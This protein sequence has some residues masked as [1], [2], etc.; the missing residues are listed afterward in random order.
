[1]FALFEGRVPHKILE[2]WIISPT[3]GLPSFGLYLTINQPYLGSLSIRVQ[4]PKKII[5]FPLL[6]NSDLFL[7]DFSIWKV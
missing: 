2:T 6:Y 1:M 4:F 3:P 5:N 7:E